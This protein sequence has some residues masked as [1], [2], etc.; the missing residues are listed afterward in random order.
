MVVD[1]DFDWLLQQLVAWS[2]A[3]PQYR[4]SVKEL[5]WRNGW[6]REQARRYNVPT[7]LHDALLERTGH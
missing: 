1:P 2:E 5:R 6:L 4:S 7:P 3:I